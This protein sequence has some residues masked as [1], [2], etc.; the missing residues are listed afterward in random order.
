M[1]H[2]INLGGYLKNFQTNEKEL[3][4]IIHEWTISPWLPY[5]NLTNI[6]LH[7]FKKIITPLYLQFPHKSNL[8]STYL[9]SPPTPPICPSMQNCIH[10]FIIQFYFKMDSQG[11][12]IKLLIDLDNI[13]T[14]PFQYLT[15]PPTSTVPLHTT[16]TNHLIKYCTAPKKTTSQTYEYIFSIILLVDY[17]SWRRVVDRLVKYFLFLFYFYFKQRVKS[18]K[19]LWTI[20]FCWITI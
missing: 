6:F 7:F 19:F 9:E 15:M 14:T 1:G 12:V 17:S 18:F 13:I 3:C 10:P 20:R 8:C 5:E 4:H 16:C 2:W 11:E